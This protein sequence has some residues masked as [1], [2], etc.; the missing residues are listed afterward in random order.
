[1]SPVLPTAPLTNEIFFS[2]SSSQPVKYRGDMIA[3]HHSHQA[4]NYRYNLFLIELWITENRVL[5]IDLIE[6][7]LV[8]DALSDVIGNCL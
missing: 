5:D 8:C 2:I 4:E 3:G 6:H 7:R 1:M